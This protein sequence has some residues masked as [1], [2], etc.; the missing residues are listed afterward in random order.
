MGSLNPRLGLAYAENLGVALRANSLGRRSSILQSNLLWALDL[1]LAAALETIGFHLPSSPLL[2]W[3]VWHLT[4]FVG[5][6]TKAT[7]LAG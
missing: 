1:P 7:V 6:T 3:R 2:V 4:G 5:T